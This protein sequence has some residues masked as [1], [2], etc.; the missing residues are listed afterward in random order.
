M[1][2]IEKLLEDYLNYIEIEKNRSPKTRENYEHYLKT[3]IKFGDI[4]TEKDITAD[5]VRD[6][7]LFLART[8]TPQNEPIKK[9]TQSYY[10]I[11]LRNFLKYLIKQDFEVLAP[12]KIELPK[13]PARQIEIIEY[14]DLERLLKAPEGNDLRS[15]R[16]KAI[17]E[18]FFSTGLRLSELC[19]L[20]RHL[21]F[22]RGEITVRGKGNK[23]RIVFLSPDARKAIKN[24]L[25]KRDKKADTEEAL[26]ISLTKAKEPK[27][28]GRIIPRTVQRLIDYYAR[29]AGIQERVTPHMLR[30][31]LHEKT[32]IFLNHGLASAKEAFENKASRVF[33]LNFK[34][35]SVN[36]DRVVG[37]CSH[38]ADKLLQIWAGGREILVTHLH[39]FFT[40]SENGLSEVEAGNLRP[41]MFVAGIKKFD[42]KGKFFYEPEFWRLVGYILGDGTLSERRHGVII[43]EKN[44]K[45]VDFYEKIIT[46]TIDYS[47]KI[48]KALKHNG[49]LL[50]IYNV[51]FLRHLRSLGITQKSSERRAPPL[52][53]KATLKEIKAFIAGF[54]DA[55]GNEGGIRLFS[56]SKELLKDF[57][58]LFLRLGIQSYIYERL[59]NVRLP[60]GK[61]IKNKIYVLYILDKESQNL[62][63]SKIPTLKNTSGGGHLQKK[64]DEKI[65]TQVLLRKIYPDIKLKMPGL[66]YFLQKKYKI[67]YL[68]RYQKLCLTRPLLNY[69][70]RACQKFSYKNSTIK[71][72]EL[73]NQLDNISWLKISK[74]NEIKLPNEK[75]YDF[76]INPNHNFITDGFISHNSFATDLLI[77][78][79]DLRSVQELLGHAN[80]S[81]TQ[82]YTHL[83][84]QQLREVHQAFHARRRH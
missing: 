71:K 5:R 56:S 84:N 49:W 46:K 82:V 76:T 7:R 57:Q 68:A 26:F 28:I 75:V 63:K 55:E 66:I 47:P 73:L 21:N 83:T 42:Q 8:K 80:V 29:K 15:L 27:I 74:I 78:G 43:A 53:F 51:K 19:S 77:N 32:R 60:S 72:L 38:P 6:F 64:E 33:S 2:N 65:P 9:N 24:Y 31:C 22:E 50:N 79:A 61:I 37:Y 14:S 10:I 54:Y 23:L 52:I 3:L 34:N 30:H 59:R 81:T 44:K 58:V 1:A 41:G 45:F 35:N 20:N 39:R 17:L 36:Y 25:D 13:I 67:K 40:V 18:T 62:F 48:A 70:L 16:D 12:D 69:F 11:A 4:K